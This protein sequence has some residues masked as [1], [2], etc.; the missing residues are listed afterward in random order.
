[1]K[2]FI[3]KPEEVRAWQFTRENFKLGI[4]EELSRAEGIV[5]F[6]YDE[7]WNEPH[8]FFMSYSEYSVVLRLGDWLTIDVNND[9][10]Y[11]SEDLFSKLFEETS[12]ETK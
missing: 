3:K 5:L 10:E 6:S 12:N 4:P 8:C 9:I 2:N 11:W 1:M 7:E